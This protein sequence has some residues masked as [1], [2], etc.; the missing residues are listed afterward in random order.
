MYFC[1]FLTGIYWTNMVLKE[2]V[3]QMCFSVVLPPPIPHIKYV[4]PLTLRHIP[5]SLFRDIKSITQ[6]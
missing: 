3:S 2:N 4:F 6:P 1:I 5:T